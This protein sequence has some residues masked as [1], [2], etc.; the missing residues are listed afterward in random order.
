MAP[1]T[2]LL[3][4]QEKETAPEPTSIQERSVLSAS[5]DDLIPDAKQIRKEA[6]LND[7]ERRRNMP[8]LPRLL[9]NRNRR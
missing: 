7:A 3:M 8:V 2:D 1:A 9:E 4:D 6:A 5:P